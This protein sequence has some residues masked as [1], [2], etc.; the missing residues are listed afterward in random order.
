MLHGPFVSGGNH[1][2]R[3]VGAGRSIPSGHATFSGQ[4]SENQASARAY[5]RTVKDAPDR[6]FVDLHP[7]LRTKVET[8][9]SDS[10]V[11][12]QYRSKRKRRFC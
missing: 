12:A 3:S 8:R 2:A 7:P 10:P 5:V 1:A 11:A 6:I 9:A 4:W